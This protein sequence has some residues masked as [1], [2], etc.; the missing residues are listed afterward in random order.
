MVDSDYKF[1]NIDASR[2]GAALKDAKMY[3]YASD[4]KDRRE[5][6]LIISKPISI[7][8]GT[9]HSWVKGI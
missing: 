1:I 6:N 8:H 3:N 5:R 2:N 4:L 9:N 7:K